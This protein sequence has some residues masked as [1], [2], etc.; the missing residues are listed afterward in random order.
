MNKTIIIIVIVIIIL[1][2][3]KDILTNAFD[4]IPYKIVPKEQSN[5]LLL[6][7]VPYSNYDLGSLEDV[8][9]IDSVLDSNDSDELSK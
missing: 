1:Y 8:K 7:N 6:N 4:L 5:T 2:L 3:N 9:T